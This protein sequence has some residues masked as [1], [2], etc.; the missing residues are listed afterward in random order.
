MRAKNV[1]KFLSMVLASVMIIGSS[2]FSVSAKAAT[3]ISLSTKYLS[4]KEDEYGKINLRSKNVDSVTWKSD[5]PSIAQVSDKY[6]GGYVYGVKEGTTTVRAVCTLYN[7][8][9][10]TVTC[11]VNVKDGRYL[12]NPKPYQNS[13]LD[14]GKVYKMFGDTYRECITGTYMAITNSWGMY[15]L[16]GKYQTMSF[17]LGH[18][19]E[20]GSKG[21]IIIYLDGDPIAEYSNLGGSGVTKISRAM[22]PIDVTLDVSNGSRVTIVFSNKD[23][24]DMFECNNYAIT[25]LTFDKGE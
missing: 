13:D 4:I 10:K 21:H 7:G 14:Y 12:K 23:N 11:K 3:K 8:K 1:K 20:Q 5:D 17:K 18:I 6:Y 22:S 16:D 25:D 15:K 24:G 2:S 19:D 9:K